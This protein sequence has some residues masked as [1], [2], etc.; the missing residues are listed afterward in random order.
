MIGGR[1]AEVPRSGAC[2]VILQNA[3]DA[4]NFEPG[5]LIRFA[6]GPY[7]DS[8]RDGHDVR[9]VK[10]DLYA[11]VLWTDVPVATM[12]ASATAL[13]WIWVAS[14]REQRWSPYPWSPH[15]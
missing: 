10:S 11:G 4:V 2:Y 12:V 8:F 15:L 7:R 1:V 3:Y 5:D 14:H 13:D 6:V 9:V